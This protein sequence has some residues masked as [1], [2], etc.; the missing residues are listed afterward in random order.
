MESPFRRRFTALL[1]PLIMKSR[2][3]NFHRIYVGTAS[4]VSA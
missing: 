2:P 4:S 3:A 1:Y